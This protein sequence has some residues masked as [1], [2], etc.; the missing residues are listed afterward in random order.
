MA[1]T[2]V[3]SVQMREAHTFTEVP[4]RPGGVSHE[5]FKYQ[6]N[7]DKWNL[8]K[9]LVKSHGNKIDGLHS[10]NGGKNVNS[11]VINFL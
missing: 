5:K 8:I 4:A 9:V 6:K 7:N 10:K 2:G 1:Q 11:N 3:N